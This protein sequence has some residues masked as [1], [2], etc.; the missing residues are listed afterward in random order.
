MAES[1]LD[2]PPPPAGFSMDVPP[3]P[4][5]FT[6]NPNGA[7]LGNPNLARQGE[8]SL[9]SANLSP[10][11]DIGGA[12][13][14]GAVLGYAA[15]EILQAGAAATR[16][17][18][19]LAPLST[20]L[21]FAS[22]AA[23]AAGRIPSAITG[24]TS[25]LASETAGQ[26]ADAK[27]ASAPVAEGV[28]LAAGGVSGEA[29][30]A[31]KTVL[32]K[33]A[34]VPALGLASKFK[35]EAAKKLLTWIDGTPQS[36]SEQ[37]RAFLDEV[38]TQVRGGQKTDAPLERIGS[39][40][41]QRG[42][43]LLSAAERDL[44]S[45]NQDLARLKYKAGS[46]HDEIG[47]ELRDKINTNM[48]TQLKARADDYKKTETMRDQLVNMS[49]G[50]GHYISN[51]PNYRKLVTDLEGELDNST[52]MK[53]SPEVQSAIG[54]VLASLKNPKEGG[55]VS[56]QAVDDLRRKLG[57]V[58]RGAPSE[59]YEALNDARGRELYARLTQLQ[60]E[61]AGGENGPHAKLLQD[62]HNSSEGLSQFR[63]KF[64]KKATALDQYQE[65]KY[66]IDAQDLPKQFF[67]SKESFRALRELT[68][69]PAFANAAAMRY[70][71]KELE[72]KSASEIRDWM[73]K[74]R[75]WL[76]DSPFV[77]SMV[78]RYATRL[79]KAEGAARNAQDFAKQAQADR[80]LLV[81][82]SLPAQ[83]AV[84]LI[85]SGNTELWDKVTP[86]IVNSPQ[87]K[88]TMVAAVRQV[89]ADM[90]ASSS[91]QNLF[92]RSIRPFLEKSGITTAKEMDEIASQL[93]QLQAKQI[94]ESQK[95]GMAKRLILNSFGGYTAGGASRAALGGYGLMVDKIPQ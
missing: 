19:Q 49:E 12:A 20:G 24:A 93:A 60:K 65:G 34:V 76:N 74:N 7:A 41:G 14:V 66:A 67:K 5:G 30:N 27:G 80:N 40:M 29:L 45:K 8:K 36:L 6:I 18:P 10:L 21:D 50:N 72:G 31:A 4:P 23:R 26:M 83:R 35:H 47:A 69:D 87:A 55:A 44:V 86:A 33:Y 61:Y 62:Y 9:R 15:P 92:N 73:N 54:K 95:L 70:A 17:I 75:G 32:Q 71:D 63:T 11:A 57:E 43:E 42:E 13:G 22:R 89:V 77:G 28:R 58:F 91:T 25:G 3:P 64:G 2:I 46:G 16:A 84:D 94:P 48:E 51:L 81:G 79:E 56:F 90:G 1:A 53:R 59:G 68:G 85:K 52:V 78:D 39:L 88:D 38:L 37:E 82:K